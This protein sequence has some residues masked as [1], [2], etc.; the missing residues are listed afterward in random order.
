MSGLVSTYDACRRTQSRASVSV[1]PS[2]VAART[3]DSPRAST[4]RSWSAA[5]ALVGER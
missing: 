4:A 2:K 1:S 3:S 5:S